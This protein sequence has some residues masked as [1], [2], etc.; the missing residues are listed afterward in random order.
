MLV[1]NSSIAR[2][3]SCLA[4]VVAKVASFN[5]NNASFSAFIAAT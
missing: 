4:F 5:A 1:A 3:S 2:C